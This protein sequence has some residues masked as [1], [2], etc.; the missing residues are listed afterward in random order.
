MG[1]QKF[2]Q[3]SES[4]CCGLR[5]GWNKIRPF[6]VD[7]GRIVQDGNM[8]ISEDNPCAIA[9][10]KTQKYHNPKDIDDSFHFF[11]SMLHTFFYKNIVYKNTEVQIC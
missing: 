4:L 11:E 9:L 3:F 1:S 5:Y 7:V 8:K 6:F 2:K 10:S